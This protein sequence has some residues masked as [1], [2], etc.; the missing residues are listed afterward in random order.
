LRCA[1]LGAVDW[2]ASLLSGEE[3]AGAWDHASAVEGY[4]VGGVAA[5]AVQGIVWFE[6][7][8]SDPEP[9][10]SREVTVTEFYG[11]NRRD[12]SSP[13]ED[14][15]PLASALRAAAEAFALSGART[16]LDAC[17]ASRD[18]LVVL[19]ET[20]DASRAVPVLRV[21]GGQVPLREYLRTR[22]L[23]IV[24]HGDDV[25]SS[26]KS[27][28]LA[29]PPPDAVAVSLGVCLEMAE[30][31]VGGLDI[32]RSMTRVERAIPDALRVL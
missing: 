21:P 19:L 15:D 1:Y 16:V 25:V 8:L 20:A 17:T 5:H 22:V 7:M 26:V 31:R 24:V 6:Q 12:G 2:L 30:A 29:D 10:G 4:S 13:R 32:L 3:L 11:P 23:E 9:G 28:K 14:S 18:R 27:T